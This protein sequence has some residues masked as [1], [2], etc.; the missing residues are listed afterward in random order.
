MKKVF[1]C[2]FVLASSFVM[3][4]QNDTVVLKEAVVTGTRDVVDIRH[5]PLTVNVI[6]RTELTEQN[7]I[8]VLP[9]VMDY[10]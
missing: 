2:L 10:V 3:F 7:Q 8:N 9:T 1:I 4:A 6:D 5:L